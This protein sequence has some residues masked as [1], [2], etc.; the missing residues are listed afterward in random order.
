MDC[1]PSCSNALASIVRMQA[2]HA[3]NVRRPHDRHV[4]SLVLCTAAR[5]RHAVSA[6]R[7]LLFWRD[8]FNLRP[9][10]ICSLNTSSDLLPSQT[11]A[12]AKSIRNNMRWRSLLQ[13]N[14]TIAH[15][16]KRTRAH[17][18]KTTKTVSDPNN[19]HVDAP[20]PLRAQAREA[21]LFVDNFLRKTPSTRQH[22]RALARTRRRARA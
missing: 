12:G 9:A 7:N 15:N 14:S 11:S 19:V 8:A 16:P 3:A 18:S 17:H 20:R 13:L 2:F 21:L 1:V 22:L 6:I 5:T 4:A 10:R